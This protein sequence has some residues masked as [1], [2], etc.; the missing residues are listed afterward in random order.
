MSDYNVAF[1]NKAC[2]FIKRITPDYLCI[3]LHGYGSNGNDLKTIANQIKN[4]SSCDFLFPYGVDKCEIGTGFQWFSL[5]NRNPS[6]MLP[7][8]LKTSKT[9][10]TFILR[11]AN[12]R[13][14]KPENIILAGFSQG[15]MLAMHLGLWHINVGHVIELSGQIIC[16]NKNAPKYKPNIVLVHG[17]DDDV[18]LPAR[19]FEASETLIKYNIPH[20]KH[21]IQNMGHTIDYN[22]IDILNKFFGELKVQ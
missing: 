18:V 21:I 3:M 20:Q 12:K 5:E 6:I 10:C 11:E 15:A 17:T 14:I 2:P 7:K 8:V 16:D 22:V 4:T 19:I 13:N 1:E 9:L